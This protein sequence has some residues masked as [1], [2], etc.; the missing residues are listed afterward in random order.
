MARQ[1]DEQVA[2][3]FPVGQRLRVLDVGMGQG[4]PALRLAQAGHKVTGV[5]RDAQMLAAA[6]R[7]A[8]SGEP[9]AS[10]SG[11]GS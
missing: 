1:L 9:W 7:E 6:A 11:S 8:L 4:T 3:R 10:G 5:E 2:G